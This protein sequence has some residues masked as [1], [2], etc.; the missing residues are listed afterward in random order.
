MQVKASTA[1][2]PAALAALRP[3][4]RDTALT[5]LLLFDMDD[6]ELKA[7]CLDSIRQGLA[8]IDEELVLRLYSTGDDKTKLA[9]AC[10][11]AVSRMR[12]RAFRKVFD[13]TYARSDLT[14]QKRRE[15][16]WNLEHFLYLN[17]RQGRAYE[18]IILELTESP[19]VDLRVRGIPLAAQ[20]GRIN[21]DMLAMFRRG[22]RA[23]SPHIRL[24]TV[25]AFSHMVERLDQLPS[26]VRDFV[27]SAV[28]KDEVARMHKADPDEDVRTGSGHLLRRLRHSAK[29]TRTATGLLGARSRRKGRS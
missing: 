15:L 18:R 29:P 11:I 12:P 24:T 9:I 14:M 17:P 4:T 2:I 13:R 27:T 26:R 7:C 3:E 25:N 1:Y 22:L 23:R 8:H 16:A 19:H 21:D 5:T 28:F 10:S 20:F 6:P